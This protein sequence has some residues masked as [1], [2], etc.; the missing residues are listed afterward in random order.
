[1]HSKFATFSRTVDGGVTKTGVVAVTSANMTWSQADAYNNLVIVSG[2]ATTFNGYN[3]VF[4]DMFRNRRNNDYQGGDPD[5]YFTSPGAKSTS[6]F[7]PRAD[8]SGR[9]GPEARTD[10][11]AGHLRYLTGGRGCEVKVAQAMIHDSRPAV[12]DQL[13]RIRRAGCRALVAYTSIQPRAKETLQRAGASLCVVR[14][15]HS[16]S[17]VV[18]SIHSKYYLLR[19][20]YAGSPGAARVFTGS[21]NWTLSA[22]RL[23]DEVILKLWEPAVVT[24]FDGNFEKMWARGT[25]PEG[26]RCA[27]M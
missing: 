14:T 10:T 20:T 15:P 21:H 2:D 8:S 7:Q 17:D 18:T 6:Y 26:S 27:P 4:D 3:A 11:V 19:G 24:A 22:L 1:M 16:N 25:T 5:G 9:M 23:N 12:I 13:V